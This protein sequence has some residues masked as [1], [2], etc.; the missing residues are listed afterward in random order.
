M[1][2]QNTPNKYSKHTPVSLVC[3]CLIVRLLS[4]TLCVN[5][6]KKQ[7]N[8]QMKNRLIM[9]TILGVGITYIFKYLALVSHTSLFDELSNVTLLLLFGLPIA[10]YNRTMSIVYTM[11]SMV[12]Y[13]IIYSLVYTQ[14]EFSI[15]WLLVNSL[16]MGFLIAVSS[17]SR[18]S[19][20]NGYVKSLVRFATQGLFVIVVY[21]F[22]TGVLVPCSAGYGFAELC[23]LQ[24]EWTCTHSVFSLV[25]VMLS[26]FVYSFI[27]GEKF[28]FLNLH[29]RLR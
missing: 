29:W 22:V 18:H 15:K 11:I 14:Y 19:M 26:P 23:M 9:T 24:I 5:V 4:C 25:P 28:P 10:Q 1:E 21:D 8:Q 16:L 27:G 3:V 2:T 6:H 12:T 13:G 17:Y 7:K 20:H